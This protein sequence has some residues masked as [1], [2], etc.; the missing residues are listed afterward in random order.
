MKPL[1][2]A[3]STSGPRAEYGP[4]Y[5]FSGPQEVACPKYVRSKIVIMMQLEVKKK[6]MRLTSLFHLAVLY[7]LS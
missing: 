7:I 2:Q 6:G 3:Y 4:S 1:I 5:L